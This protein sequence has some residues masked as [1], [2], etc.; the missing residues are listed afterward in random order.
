MS[1]VD[2][3]GLARQTAGKGTP[4]TTMTYFPPVERVEV[5][6]QAT[7]I[8]IEETQGNRFAAGLDYGTRFFTVA[9]TFIPRHSSFP[10]I[11]SG[12]FGQPTTGAAVSGVYPHVFDVAAAGKIPEWHS[13]FVVRAD[14]AVDIID[15]FTDCRGEE[16]SV[17]VAAN[18]YMRATARWLALTLDDTQPAPTPTTDASGRIKFP[19]ALIYLDDGG[20]EVAVACQSWGFTYTNGHDTDQAVLGST[21]LYDLPHGNATCQ[22]RFT[23]RETLSEHYRRALLTEPES[24]QVRMVANNGL[25]AGN[26]REVEVIAYA[27]ETTEAP[28]DVEASEVLKM[29]TVTGSVKYDT[30]TSKFIQATVKNTVASY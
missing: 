28:A 30:V 10:R 5:R 26:L 24:I 4:V 18:G 13:M 16:L 15:L 1:R 12:F 27:M 9:P 11:L 6:D 3:Y 23:P 20:G 2:I 21:E 19:H 29:I 14:P 25:A 17:D 7:D 8:E 22:I